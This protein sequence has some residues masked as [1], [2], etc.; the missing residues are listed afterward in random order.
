MLF[1][2]IHGSG[3]ITPEGECFCGRLAIDAPFVCETDGCGWYGEEPTL[4]LDWDWGERIGEI[5]DASF[6]KCP[7]CGR[8]VEG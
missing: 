6:Y 3:S 7:S 8:E 2:P 5:V 4:R 1:C